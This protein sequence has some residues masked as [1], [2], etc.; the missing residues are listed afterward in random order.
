MND[1]Y[2]VN[3]K[4]PYTTIITGKC[5][6]EI[7][8]PAIKFTYECDDFQ[9][10]AFTKIEKGEDLLVTAHT[11]AGKTTIAEYAVMKTIQNKKTTIYT[12]PIKSLSNEKFNDFKKKF[13][14]KIDNFDLGIMTGDNKINPNGNCVIMTAEILRNALYKDPIKNGDIDFVSNIGCVILDEV[15]FINDQ[16]RGKV[17]EEIIILLR[18]DIQLICLSATIDKAE[19]F[20]EWIGTTRNKKIN[21]ITTDYRPIPLKHMIYM[22]NHMHTI[23]HNNKYTPVDISKEF[24]SESR[25]NDNKL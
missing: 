8:N 2:I 13:L 10:H 18:Q 9:K 5:T 24:K 19:Y 3:N 14:S 25:I 16:D 4:M 12:S 17:W 23:Y 11:G 21:L 15:H 22:H 6:E 7:D 20:A 1:L